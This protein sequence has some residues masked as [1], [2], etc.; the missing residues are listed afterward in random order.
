[1]RTVVLA[2]DGL[3]Y[4][5][6]NDYGLSNLKQNKHGFHD[7]SMLESTFTPL[8]FSAIITGKDPRDFGYTT[9]Y[10]E[11]SMNKSTLSS[12]NNLIKPFV[13]IKKKFFPSLNLYKFNK[14]LQEAKLYDELKISR[15]MNDDMKK[16]TIF[17]KLVELGYKINPVSVPSYNESLQR[18][19]RGMVMNLINKNYNVRRE[20]INDLFNNIQKE[21]MKTVT[22]IPD[23]YL[24]F[25]YV[26]LPDY[27]HHLCHKK[28]EYNMI[29]DI[30][31]KL[32]QLPLLSELKNLGIIILSDH[33][34]SHKFNADG[35]DLSGIHNK[36]GFWSINRDIKKVP[37]TTLDFYTLI[38]NM[39]NL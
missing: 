4:E 7:V 29:I 35:K 15:D 16:L 19:Q 36:K 26:P 30:Y 37:K 18:N 2:L 38:L 6:V 17:N 22:L 3:D 23:Y 24:T 27:A 34:Y 25:F 8:C 32:D 20:S 9:K 31:T 14:Q 21:W 39:I 12:Y 10:I 33:G 1:L 5:I 28:N 11:N 13:Y